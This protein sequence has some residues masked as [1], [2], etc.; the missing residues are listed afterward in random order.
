MGIHC[1]GTCSVNFNSG[2]MVNLTANAAMGS[3]F[4]GWSGACSGMAACSVTMTAAKAVT[5]T[6]NVFVG[7]PTVTLSANSVTFGVSGLRIT[8]AVQNVTLSNTGNGTLNIASI[9]ITGANGGDFGFS[10]TSTCPTGA[11]GVLAAGANCTIAVT[12]RPTAPGPR[13][14]TVSISD[15]AAGSPQAV[16]LSSFGVLVQGDFDADGKTDVGVWR[17]SNGN[18]YIIP[19]SKPNSPTVT[20]WGA[21]LLGDIPVRGDY[22]GDGKSD[23]AVFRPSNGFWY[24][25]PSSNPTTFTAQQW[26]AS[27][28]IPVPGDYD[29]DGKTDIAVF[30]PSNGFW[31]IIPSSNPGTPIVRQFGLNG[32]IPVPGDYD[33]DGKTD[34]AVWRGSTGFWF[35]IPSSNPNSPIV[36]QWGSSSLGDMPVLADYDGDGK[37]DIGVWR[38]STGGWYIIPSS[39][40]GV[41]I[42]R[43]WGETGDIP[44][45]A[46]YDGDQIADIAVWRPSNGNWYVI[47]SAA[48]ATFTVTQ[49]GASS[50]VPLQ[51]PI[52]Q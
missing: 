16:T 6:F 22:D 35:I 5:A 19:S 41:P 11:G 49:F 51:K 23:V 50:D 40:P 10:N 39:N 38:S 7:T 34:I 48:P 27:G 37:T 52:G 29:G 13:A 21:S 8:S 12:T 36:T 14:A 46:D 1:P 33:G 43:Q 2:T 17:G 32:D 24:I 31:Y 9:T 28:D 3:T 30:R 42:V 45:P 26:G 15:N 25:I 47:P 4:A 44:V 18:W 20:Q